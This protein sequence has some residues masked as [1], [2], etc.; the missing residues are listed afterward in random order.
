MKILYVTT[1]GITMGFFKNLIR[2][3]IESGNRVDIA[4]NQS[5]YKVPDCYLKWGCKVFQISTSRFPFSL[6]NFK[7]IKQLKEIAQNY[8]IVHCHTPL[9]GFSTRMACK[10]IKS[11][12]RP[13]VLYTAH[14]FHFFKGSSPFNWFLYY[15]IE[16]LCSRW[17]DV[18]FTINTEDYKL[19]KRKF[20]A[21][22]T[23]YVPG[24]G[25]D[26]L[27]FSSSFV[28]KRIKR[29]ELNL[30]NDAFVILSVG[31]L[32]KNK[33]HKLVIKA[34]SNL[35]FKKQ[36][37]YVIAGT[38]KEKD[39]LIKFAKKCGVN[40]HCLG[41]RNDVLELYKCADLFVLPSIREGLNVSLIEAMSS[42]LLCFASKIRGNSDLLN[43]EQ[44]FGCNDFRDL[45]KKITSAF[46]H[47][48]NIQ[49]QDY[50]KYD[51]HEINKTM[52]GIYKSL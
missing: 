27:K 17:T 1:V 5:F 21:K 34:L 3:L 45:G 32:N 38:G 50:L 19:A 9:A 22:R 26:T 43:E 13:A 28:D 51:Y 36:I 14:G 29:N 47:E 24:V 41:Y 7:A 49:H 33:N 35:G 37:H 12:N 52:L 42:G 8:D 2:E 11:K 44:L 48:L 25:V 40:L 6:G 16:K 30:P 39:R 23:E 46:D 20:K 15:P 18:L 10:R 31:E 4:T